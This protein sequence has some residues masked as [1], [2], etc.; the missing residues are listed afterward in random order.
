[1]RSLFPRLT[2]L[3]R[4]Q[5]LAAALLALFAAAP[6]QAWWDS[7][8]T[9]R[10]AIT[11]DPAAAGAT[12]ADPLGAT[13]VLIRLHDANFHFTDAKSDGGDLR[14]VAA[15]DKTPLAFHFEKFDPL[16][17]EALVWV[18]VPAVAAGAKT[19][20]WL[21]YGNTDAKAV[22]IDDP[23]GTYDSD[24]VLVYHFSNVSPPVPA[25]D[26][27]GGNNALNAGAVAD[28]TIIGS[29][30]TLDGHS[31]VN[32]PAS[33]SLAWSAG[34]AMTWSA[35]V[36]PAAPSARAV[37]FSRRDGANALV[38]GDDNGSPFVEVTAGGIP[39]R[40]AAGAALPPNTWHH[41]AVTAGGGKILLYV[42]GE[43]YASLDAA[44]PALNS[45]AQIGA[46][47]GGLVGQLDEL[48]VSKV[49][50][51]AGFLKL[52]AVSQG[53][54][55]A[56]E[57]LVSL[58]EPEKPTNWLSFLKTG[59]F[60][61]IISSLTVD[62]WVVI[63]I[64]MVMAAISWFVMIT[65]V[66]YLN[67]IA[68]GNSIFMKEWEQVAK[69]LT[70]LDHGNEDKAKTLGGRVDAKG[71]KALRRSPI[72]RIY[73]IGAREIRHRLLADRSENLSA[74]SIQAIRASLDGG[75]VRESQKLNKMI[76]LLTI[77]ISGGPFLGLLGTVVG[78]MITFAAVAAAGEVNVNAIAPGIAAALLATVAGLAVAIPALFGY[79]YI[80][81]RIK[82]STSDMHV[83]IDEFVTKM[84]E[85]YSEPAARSRSLTRAPFAPS[86]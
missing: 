85:H 33:P 42:D 27:I 30:L 76:V 46:E 34:G 77:A 15:D 12:L 26:A 74:R 17:D 56:A 69:D 18:N 61:I 79:N 16:L 52:V 70:V 32:L 20:I 53:G 31:V 43:S 36:H 81:T 67:S 38:I 37:I 10:K 24:T 2:A 47:T 7:A 13:P 58:G 78:V 72:Y 41:L 86:E 1:M 44:L 82:D 80:V 48:Q 14:F 4:P 60:G 9:Q 75:I 19:T 22:K 11:I 6:A 40:S 49:A 54:S 83:F 35:W 63:C 29:G 62:G 28:N 39:Q 68:R 21:Y 57:K 71:E 23:K 25:L 50:R 59:Y 64:L 51:S 73:R 55:D 8:W 3:V 5:F 65:K 66:S 84:A 45:S